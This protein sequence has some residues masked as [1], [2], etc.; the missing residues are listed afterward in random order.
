MDSSVSSVPP[1]DR[2]DKEL[3]LILEKCGGTNAFTVERRKKW[4]ASCLKFMI[5]VCG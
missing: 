5:N 3:A 1:T 2:G 4:I